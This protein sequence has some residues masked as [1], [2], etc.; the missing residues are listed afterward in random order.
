MKFL[1]ARNAGLI[2][3]DSCHL[4]L[5]KPVPRTGKHRCPR[6]GATLHSRIPRSLSKTWALL[7]A[8]TILYIPANTLPVMS[9]VY[10]GRGEPSTILQ[11]V[12]HLLAEGMWPLATIVFVASIFVPLLKLVV[13]SGLLISIR[14]ASNWR[15]LD[16]TRLYRLTEFV[17]RW[18]MV[19]IFVIGVLTALVQFGNLA[20]IEPGAGALS[21]AAVVVLTMFAAHTFDPRL[22]WDHAQHD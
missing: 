1:T 8:A 21:F 19:D 22:L 3:C 12:M 14:R 11:G 20:S 6:C 13:L 4:L 2:A 5:R 16:R 17:G 7:I 15:T 18:S 10:L 9:V